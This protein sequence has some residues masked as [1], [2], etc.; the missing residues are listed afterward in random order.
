MNNLIGRIS[1]GSGLILNSLTLLF[2]DQFA[3]DFVHGICEGVALALIIGG[4]YFL[5][6]AR[7]EGETE[8]ECGLCRWKHALIEKWNNRNGESQ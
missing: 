2:R 4:A 8:T 1:L 3:S 6:R 5:N 7:K